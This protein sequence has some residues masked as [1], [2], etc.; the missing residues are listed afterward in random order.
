M[1]CEAVSSGTHGV[2]GDGSCLMGAPVWPA[3]MPPEIE[4]PEPDIPQWD[5][6][7]EPY[8]PVVLTWEDIYGH[9][10]DNAEGFFGRKPT[11][12]EVLHIFNHVRLDGIGDETDLTDVLTEYVYFYYSGWGKEP[13]TQT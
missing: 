7:P 12:E 9:A 13:A 4:C 10:L 5:G 2:P 1:E 8:S 3:G 11:K 6:M